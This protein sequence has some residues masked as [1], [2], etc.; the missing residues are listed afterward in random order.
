MSLTSVISESSST[1]VTGFFNT[2][3]PKDPLLVVTSNFAKRKIHMIYMNSKME[4]T[5]MKGAQ[6]MSK[7]RDQDNGIPI[8]L[9]NCRTFSL[10]KVHK[11]CIQEINQ[12]ALLKNIL[13]C[14][15]CWLPFS[16]IVTQFY[17]TVFVSN[18]YYNVD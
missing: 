9:T 12:T 16:L 4:C 14:S 11:L 8:F 17:I 5:D 7:S 15:S 1:P 10:T 2:A 3:A 6:K 13:K 18:V